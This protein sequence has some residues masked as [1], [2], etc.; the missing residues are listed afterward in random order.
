MHVFRLDLQTQR[1]ER[2][3]LTKMKS[4]E[5]ER[6]VKW[7]RAWD[8]RELNMLISRPDASNDLLA[9]EGPRHAFGGVDDGL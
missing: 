2:D 6:R 3:H 7:D 1:Q 4:T 5:L 9:C 8:Q